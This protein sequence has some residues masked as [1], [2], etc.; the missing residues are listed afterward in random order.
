M[1]KIDTRRLLAQSYQ[2]WRKT[3]P[4]LGSL[5]R[6]YLVLWL[7]LAVLCLLMVGIVS[8]LDRSH[9][10]W[11]LPLVLGVMLGVILR[12]VGWAR[13]FVATWPWL[14]DLLDWQA[15]ER[16]AS[17]SPPADKPPVP[18][19][20]SRRAVLIGIACVAAV[21]AAILG[22]D[23]MLL[24]LYDARP[25]NAPSQVIIYT[26]AWCPYCE[27]LRVKLRESAIPYTELD[28]EKS[29]AASY[30]HRS[31]GGRGIPVTV[32]GQEVIYGLD[33]EK[34]DK[35]LRGAGYAPAPWAGAPDAT[36]TAQ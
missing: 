30:G 23:R 6:K 22:A 3:P 33:R 19:T 16:T 17:A 26:T 15:V 8:L 5:L 1:K 7:V 2:T 4:R 21:L 10:R 12:D 25:G 32:V 9:L 31:V 13:R 11:L 24:R 28:I 36:E 35:A 29:L 14:Q 20:R 27:M 34:L 18:A